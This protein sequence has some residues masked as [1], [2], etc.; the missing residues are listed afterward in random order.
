MNAPTATKS[1]RGLRAYAAAIRPTAADYAAASA[2]GK[3][4][5]KLQAAADKAMRL[6]RAAG[7]RGANNRAAY[8]AAHGVTL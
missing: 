7:I 3:G 8:L 6:E 5:D 4:M 1:A 2:C